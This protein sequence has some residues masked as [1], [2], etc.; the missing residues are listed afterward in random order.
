[1]TGGKRLKVALVSSHGGHFTEILTLKDV[2]EEHETFFITYEGITPSRLERAY[3]ISNKWFRNPFHFAGALIKV[4]RILHKERPEV[5]F[6]TGAEIAIPIFFLSKFLFR[7]RLIYVE[8]SAQVTTPSFTGKILYYITDLFLVQWK[9]LLKK[10]GPR[11][12]Y[13]GG[14]I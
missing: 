12:R 7:C 6:S 11:A 10:Y 13:E 14:L 9:P 4:F 2:F 1:M 8:C 5:I 3:F